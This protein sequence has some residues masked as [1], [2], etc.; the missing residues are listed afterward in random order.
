[1]FWKKQA[2]SVRPPERLDQRG[3]KSPRLWLRL[4]FWGIDRATSARLRLCRN[5]IERRRGF[6]A[7]GGRQGGIRLGRHDE[8][9]PLSLVANAFAALSRN[10]ARHGRRRSHAERHRLSHRPYH[11]VL[12]VAGTL[13]RQAQVLSNRRRFDQPLKHRDARDSP[14]GDTHD[15]IAGSQSGLCRRHSR[16][17]IADHDRPRGNWT[18][19]HLPSAG[20]TCTPSTV[21]RKLPNSAKSAPMRRARSIGMAKPMPD[22]Q[23]TSACQIR[24][25]SHHLAVQVDQRAAGVQRVDSRV[26]LK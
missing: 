6:L 17:H 4:V 24:V 22:D 8:I 25:D 7:G 3:Y 1:M 2:T 16:R 20:S 23:G 19:A 10:A 5:R 14:A 12:A 11:D 9:S 18:V 26:G 13:D 21:R 15:H